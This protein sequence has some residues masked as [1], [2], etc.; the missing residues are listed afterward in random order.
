MHNC[1]L[2]VFPLL[3]IR[4]LIRAYAQA[5]STFEQLPH[6]PASSRMPPSS[7]HSCPRLAEKYASLSFP[8]TLSC[9]RFRLLCC[10]ERCLVPIWMA[11]SI[12][13]RPSGHQECGDIAHRRSM[14]LANPKAISRACVLFL[15]RSIPPSP[16]P[17]NRPRISYTRFDADKPILER[18]PS[19]VFRRAGG[20]QGCSFTVAVSRLRAITAE[21]RPN[22]GRYHGRLRLRAALACTASRMKKTKDHTKVVYTKACSRT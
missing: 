5:V 22:H 6:V 8:E 17:P 18:V 14:L 1:L 19:A 15:A 13:N 10:W 4:A 20:Y 12:T 9:F 16:P 3:L 21:S 11:R 2:Y 7:Q